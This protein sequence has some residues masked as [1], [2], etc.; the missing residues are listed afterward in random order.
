VPTDSAALGQLIGHLRDLREDRDRADDDLLVGLEGL[1]TERHLQA[2][3]D[4]SLPV[5]DLSDAAA[6]V[7]NTAG[8]ELP[9]VAEEYVAHLHDR[10]TPR[11]RAGA[12]ALWDGR[13]P[14]SNHLL[15]PPAAA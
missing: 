2:L 11:Q 9:T 5:L 4:E 6:V 13:R 8:L 7:W 15:R 3:F 12:A 1:R 14:C 10:T